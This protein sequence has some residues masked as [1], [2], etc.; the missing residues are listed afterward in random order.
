MRLAI[1]TGPH[2]AHVDAAHLAPE[3]ARAI[4]AALHHAP[5]MEDDAVTITSGRDSHVTGL[6][7]KGRALDFRGRAI[8]GRDLAERRRRGR[9]WAARVGLDLGLRYDVLWEEYSDPNRDHLHVEYE[10]PRPS[11]NALLLSHA[12]LLAGPRG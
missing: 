3:M 7:P 9:L 10:G 11:P 12:S 6:H 2:G 5:P 4:E 1:K 8:R